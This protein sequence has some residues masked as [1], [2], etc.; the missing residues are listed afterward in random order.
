M[1]I[2]VATISHETNTFAAEQNDS[3]AC[4]RL[5]RG[6]ELLG[7]AHPRSFVG[8]FAEAMA[9]PDCE[10]VPIAG[11]GFA[12]GGTVGRKVYEECRQIILD[13]VRGAGRLDGLYLALHGAMVAEEPYLDA[14][15]ELVRSLRAALGDDLPMVAT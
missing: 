15:G 11:M 6:A 1:R 3:M 12:H 5:R 7:G 8:G 2:A 13:G 10:L 4:V 14:E 9:G